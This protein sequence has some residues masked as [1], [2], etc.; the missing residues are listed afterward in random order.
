MEAVVRRV[1]ECGNVVLREVFLPQNRG[2]TSCNMEEKGNKGH[3]GPIGAERICKF[4]NQLREGC[5]NHTGNIFACGAKIE[6]ETVSCN[7]TCSTERKK[8]RKGSPSRRVQ[9][10]FYPTLPE[11]GRVS[12]VTLTL[13]VS[14]RCA[15]LVRFLMIS[16]VQLNF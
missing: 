6:Y 10:T 16:L 13:L 7:K 12:G 8:C 2:R 11:K 4:R 15:R 3:N 1:A 5:S 14:S 9:R